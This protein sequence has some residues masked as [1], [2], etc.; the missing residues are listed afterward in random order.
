MRNSSYNVYY[1]NNLKNLVIYNTLSNEYQVVESVDEEV[2][3]ELQKKQMIT[4][5]TQQEEQAKCDAIFYQKVYENTLNITIITT[6]NCNFSCLYCAQD[7]EGINMSGE[8]YLGIEKYIIRNIN[9]FVALRVTLF[10]GEPTVVTEKYTEFLKN[11]KKI[12]RY[13]SRNFQVAMVTNGYLLDDKMIEMLYRHQVTQYTITLDGSPELHNHYRVHKD[14]SQTFEQIYSNLLN[15]KNRKDLK[16]LTIVIRINVTEKTEKGIEKWKKIYDELLVD[17]RFY[18]ELSVVEDR[19]GGSVSGILPELVTF[20]DVAYDKV[21]SMFATQRNGLEK[22]KTNMFVCGYINK[23]SLTIDC[24]GDVRI[25]SKLYM[26]N[27]VGKL[28]KAGRI[29]SKEAE[30]SLFHTKSDAKCFGCSLEPLCHGKR[31]GFTTV[32]V[33]SEIVDAI[34]EVLK[35][36]GIVIDKSIK[37]VSEDVYPLQ[38]NTKLL[39]TLSGK[40]VEG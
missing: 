18:L 19:G 40:K 24:N 9:S 30:F 38:K 15:I 17:S 28:T 23:N 37:L 3:S 27:C 36:N 4:H 13:Y 5:L 7:C 32:C 2:V 14:G 25:C 26:D 33:K 34:E 1:Y 11:I 12:C 8:V 31:C 22:L 6:R 29:M 35:S 16:R 20:S 10:G 21:K 39:T